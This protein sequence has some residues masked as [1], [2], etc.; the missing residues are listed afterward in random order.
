MRRADGG[1]D[2]VAGRMRTTPM[3]PM[4]F[5][6][7]LVRKFGLTFAA[8]ALLVLPWAVYGQDAG[9]AP[10][11]S[12]ASLDPDGGWPKTLQSGSTNITLFQ[13]QVESLQGA[14]LTAT[15]AVAAEPV[16]GASEQYGTVSFTATANIDK[17]ND[18]ATLTDLTITQGNFPGAP[19]KGASYISA[20]QSLLTAQPLQLSYGRIESSLAVEKASASSNSAQPVLNTPPQIIFSQTPA[21]LVLIDGAPALR[22][23]TGTN[24]LRVLN[25]K[26]FILLDQSSGTY[27]LR[28]LGAWMQATAVSGPWT[29]AANPPAALAQA[30][31][32]AQSDNSIDLMD[33]TSDSKYTAAQV[34]VYVST[35]P[36]EL[37]Q[38]NGP[39]NF[40]PIPNTQI[41]YAQNTENE[42][43]LYLPNQQ[44]YFLVS[45][46]WFDSPSLQSSSW[47]F[48]PYDQLPPD[49]ANIPENHPAGGALVNVPGTAPAQ[50][51]VIANSIPNTATI[52]RT[53]PTLDV[54]YDGAPQF[55][56][57]TG[58]TLYYA[59]NTLTPVVQVS[60]NSY[61]A[62]Q[63]GVWFTSATPAGPWVVAVSVPS[64]IY[65]IPTSCP[66]HYVTYV[67][68]YN[69]TPTTVVVGYTPGYYGTVVAPAGVVVYGTGYVYPV[70]CSTI[71]VPPPPTYGYGAGFSCGF[72]TGFAFGFAAGWLVGSWCHPSGCGWGNNVVINNYHNYS[73]NNF[74]SYHHWNNNVVN[75]NRWNNNNFNNHPNNN[76]NNNHPN[77][78][79]A[80]NNRPGVNNPGVRNDNNV[81]AGKDGNVY[82]NNGNGF[83][84]YNGK[85]WQPAS[86]PAQAPR[87]DNTQNYLQNQQQ[88][89][90]GGDQ[91]TH[92]YSQ[93]GRSP[94][95]GSPAGGSGVRG[96]GGAGGAAGGGADGRKFW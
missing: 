95:A 81:Y 9:S 61:Y 12:Q 77:N 25:T 46:R 35:T 49:F 79:F 32:L 18:I 87:T 90:Q 37:I 94:D 93:Y 54:A 43:V 17:Q 82:R 34:T 52:N 5:V 2:P 42:L 7:L 65:S 47:Q 27:Y 56:P 66:I 3:N 40:A 78:N 80:A 57:V 74:N 21:V 60:S 26:A 76:F 48:V 15:M 51:A 19:D 20:L 91:Q 14:Q 92:N 85:G 36:A 96:F 63:N 75:Y 1:I 41:L 69:S 29:V 4:Q 88:A 53:G 67:Q 16:G 30:L 84:Q 11:A 71:W 8:A 13:P 73:F 72:G 44:Y 38:T 55:Q 68:V 89:R 23:F 70:Y 45:G 24:F 22:A 50:Q 59:A 62:V 33:P 31:T 83:E 64:V 86:S 6:T 58:T 39:P 10:V 28:L